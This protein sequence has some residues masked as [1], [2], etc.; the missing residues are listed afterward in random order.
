VERPVSGQRTDVNNHQPGLSQ[1]AVPTRAEGH[2]EGKRRGH[3]KT[4][5]KETNQFWCEAWEE[6]E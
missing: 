2:A 6:S 3:T 4:D 5:L 1:P